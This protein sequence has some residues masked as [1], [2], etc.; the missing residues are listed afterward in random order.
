MQ[1][2]LNYCCKYFSSR[3]CT[4][5]QYKILALENLRSM[6]WEVVTKVEPD[7]RLS[8]TDRGVNEKD[9]DKL[10]FHIH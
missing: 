1:R 4:N 2:I 5:K 7:R 8:D 3:Y 9:V 6:R 10:W